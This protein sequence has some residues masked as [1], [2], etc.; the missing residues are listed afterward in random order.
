MSTILLLLD[1]FRHDYLKEITTPFLWRC[2]QEGEYYYNVV[3]SMGFCERTEILTGLEGDKTGFFTAIGFDPQNSPYVKV[4]LM[5]FLGI[6]EDITL[7]PLRLFSR[8]FH[9]QVQEKMRYLISCQFKEMGITMPSYFIPYSWLPYF[10][11]TE[12]RIDHRNPAAFQVP[13]ILTLLAEAGRTYCYDTFTALNFNSPYQS[14]ADRLNA[15]ICDIQKSPKDLY[16]VYIAAPDV[17]GHWYGPDSLDFRRVLR[18]LDKDLEHFVQSLEQKVPGNRYV[19]LGD[20]G[21]MTVNKRIDA[22]KEISRLLRLVRLRKGRDVIYF[23][24]STM[25][26]LWAI[27]DKAR[28]M[29]PVVLTKSDMFN[30]NGTWM[31][32]KIA[33]RNNVPL[34]DRRYGD[35]LWVANPGTLIFPD[36]FHIRRPCKG[37]HGYDPHLPESRGTCI[38]WG[39][40]IPS[41]KKPV[42]PLSGVFNVIKRSLEL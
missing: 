16:L 41:S 32:E 4:P 17:F 23:L 21:M 39:S 5:R 15:V 30:R 1:A 7:F 20:H 10:S 37:M 19:F 3:Q 14:D 18:S 34:S 40:G 8:N 27:S 22:A 6:I 11:L 29:L 26:R 24:D 33:K 42:L 36:Y 12:D 13:T 2:A 31:D 38:H 25:V 9:T 28:S 35:Y